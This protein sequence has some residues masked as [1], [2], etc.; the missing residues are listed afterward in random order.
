[1]DNPLF[2]FTKTEIIEELGM[3]K[4]TLY[5][6]LPTFEEE[7]IVIISRKIGKT[8]LYKLSRE[9]YVVKYLRLI[10]KAHVDPDGAIGSTDSIL[11]SREIEAEK[12]EPA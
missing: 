11:A 7:G 5:K 9:N 4:R 8:K 10:E 3:S 12:L 6:V 1:M 2:D